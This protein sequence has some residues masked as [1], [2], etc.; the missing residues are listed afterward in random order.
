MSV[1]VFASRP[2]IAL[3]TLIFLSCSPVC[4]GEP[5]VFRFHLEKQPLNEALIR[6]ASVT[7]LELIFN[8][9]QLRVSP[10]L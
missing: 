6:I 4:G 8:S 2:A 7:G 5:P 10:K 1:P 9:D 3:Y